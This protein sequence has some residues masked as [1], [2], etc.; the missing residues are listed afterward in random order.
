MITNVRCTPAVRAIFVA[1]LVAQMAIVVTGAVVRVTNSGLGC[2]TWPECVE[3]SYVPT[4]R[5]AETWHKYVEFGNRMLTFALVVLAVAAIVAV[6]ADMRRRSRLGL[7]SRRVLLLLACIPILGTV[8]QAV[9][10]GITVLTGLHPA[11]VSAHFLLSMAIIAGCVALVVRSRDPG[12]QP[13]IMLVRRE[14]RVLTWGLVAIAGVVVLLGVIVTG[15]GPHSGDPLS[16]NRF[17]FDPRTVSWLHADVVLLF[18]GLLAALLLALRLTDAPTGAR[19][20]AWILTG[21]AVAQGAVGYIQY[22]TGLPIV[23][24]IVHVT[25]AVC[26]WAAVLFVPAAERSRG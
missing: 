5:Q 16:E 6:I 2:P 9:L 7:P 23:A 11:T 4:T 15:S 12:D 21:V 25:G 14:I 1:N 8:A 24:V 13:V 22:F 17:S 20:A 10:G 19:R 26:V 3:G 18:L